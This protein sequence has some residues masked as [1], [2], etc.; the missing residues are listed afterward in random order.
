MATFPRMIHVAQAMLLGASA[1]SLS[2]VAHAAASGQAAGTGEEAAQAN[3]AIVVT[4]SRIAK[5]GF[6]TP[7]PVTA[8]SQEQLVQTAPGTV[9]DALRALPAL[10]NS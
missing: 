10:T 1:L 4:G 3:D 5:T 6:S 9:V 7:T 2:T 8:L